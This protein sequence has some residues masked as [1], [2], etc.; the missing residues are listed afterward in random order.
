MAK[1]IDHKKQARATLDVLLGSMAQNGVIYLGNL[2]KKWK[3]L[4]M[5]INPKRLVHFLETTG[6]KLA[7]SATE[8]LYTVRKDLSTAFKHRP[9]LIA[10]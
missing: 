7:R 10:I 1:K 2:K 6:T 3:S 8:Y 4:K 5:L 9:E